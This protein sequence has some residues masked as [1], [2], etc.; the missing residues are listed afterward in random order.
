LDAL[1]ERFHEDGSLRLYDSC[2]DPNAKVVNQ[3]YGDRRAIVSFVAVPGEL[4]RPVGLGIQTALGLHRR[5]R[6]RS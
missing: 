3:I 5:I 4:A 6:T 2:S 1:V